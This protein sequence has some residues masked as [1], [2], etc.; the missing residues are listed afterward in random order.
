MSQN[1]L[2]WLAG[3]DQELLKQCHSSEQSKVAAVGMA[4]TIP[5]ITGFGS[6]WYY[7]S[8]VFPH[9]L[10][11]ATI[12]LLWAFVIL[13]IDRVLLATYRPLERR[14]LKKVMQVALRVL[15]AAVLGVAIAHPLCLH[16]FRD[17]IKLR[18][19]HELGGKITTL[20][21]D[22]EDALKAIRND[23]DGGQK[24]ARDEKAKLMEESMPASES[25]IESRVRQK[26]SLSASSGAGKAA[27][28]V[29]IADL[30]KEISALTDAVEKAKKATTEFNQALYDERTFGRNDYNGKDVTKKPAKFFT[31]AEQRDP[32]KCPRT[33]ELHRLIDENT[34][35]IEKKVPLIAAKQL[36]LAS[37]KEELL[38]IRTLEGDEVAKSEAAARTEVKAELEKEKVARDSRLGALTVEIREMELQR[39]KELARTS[40]TFNARIDPMKLRIAGIMDPLEETLALYNVIFESDGTSIDPQSRA[41]A[42][43]FQ[44]ML[45][46]G[47]FF[48]VDLLPIVS[49]MLSVGEYD[50]L[51]AMRELSS[52]AQ[53]RAR[54]R[55][56]GH[57]A[58]IADSKQRGHDRRQQERAFHR[59]HSEERS[60]EPTQDSR[61]QPPL[62][63]PVQRTVRSEAL[64]PRPPREPVRPPE[65][66]QDE[67]D[68]LP[69]L[70]KRGSA[71]QGSR[72]RGVPPPPPA[73]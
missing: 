28:Q 9:P 42:G 34:A 56:V 21:A 6:M 12:A 30:E 7:A 27:K 50:H 45:T 57:E 44:V 15:L 64:Q 40:E 35:V 23:S 67:D 52:K 38:K 43:L 47:I 73:I 36:E 59:Q 17:S 26:L 48:L 3:A 24:A 4:V 31:E 39:E 69:G 70:P 8:K 62:S 29:V 2:F 60:P 37:A 51:L 20:E 10:A 32:L 65:A 19:Q 53:L 22:R 41:K 54:E 5:S 13:T 49:K 68:G 1:V 63:P 66:P 11:I 58:E 61:R 55:S 16:Q 72:P 71:P 46:F 33:A 25:Q 18:F 14:W